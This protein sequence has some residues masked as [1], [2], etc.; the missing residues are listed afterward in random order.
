MLEGLAMHVPPQP[1]ASAAAPAATEL[2][3][4]LSRLPPRAAQLL[5]QRVL[6]ARPAAECARL[7]GTNE[8]AI[9]VQVFRA[10]RLLMT[11]LS[12]P[13]KGV[14]LPSDEAPLAPDEELHCAKALAEALDASLGRDDLAALL[15]RVR[16]LA[17][18]IRRVAQAKERAEAASPARRRA[19]WLRRLVIAALVVLALWLHFRDRW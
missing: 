17:P 15:L 4:A 2:F 14:L 18:E 13:E 3:T 6:D 19:E 1:D 12:A 8:G 5:G 7:Y 9:A 11:A 10:A 16:A